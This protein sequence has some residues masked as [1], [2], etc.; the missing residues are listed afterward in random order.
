MICIYFFLSVTQISVGETQVDSCLASK[1]CLYVQVLGGRAFLDH[2]MEPTPTS[3][4]QCSS[5]FVLH[6]LFRGQRFHSRSIPCACEPKINESFLLELTKC[7]E[8][9]SML[10]GDMSEEMVS[11]SS[12]LAI[13]DPIELVLTKSNERGE[14]ELVGVCSVHWRQLLTESSG[15]SNVTAEMGGVSSEAKITAGLLDLKLEIIPKSSEVLQGELL[16]AQVGLERQRNSE[17]ER[18]FL[19]YAKQWWKEYLQIRVAH[20]QRL[21]KIF[22]PDERGASHPVCR[23]VTPLRAGRMLDS[24]R[25]AARFVSLI[26]LEKKSSVGSSG[27]SCDSWTRAHCFIALKKGVSP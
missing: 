15:R 2:L 17:R 16:S 11:Y 10:F 22:A 21:V 24:P 4:H 12:A 27:G 3:C 5:S 1:R 26:P 14:G 8:R 23:Y 25:H 6:V 18:L 7:C 9:H 13:T 20:S 19:V